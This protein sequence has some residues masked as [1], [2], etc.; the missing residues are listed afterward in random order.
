[1]PIEY[2]L[3]REGTLVLAHATGTLSLE[4]FISMQ[5][6]MIS[7]QDLMDPH[8]T[9]LDARG[10][11]DIQ[12]TE[13][14]LSAIA[15][16]L[17]SGSKKLGARK[18]AIVAHEDLAF[19]LGSKYSVVEKGVNETVIVFINIDVARIWLGIEKEV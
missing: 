14:D 12:M 3:K 13:K 15:Q 8:D 10:V 18:L 1:M 16:S 19:L 17:T 4:D 9:L 5:K 6:K 7:D 2:K 11:S